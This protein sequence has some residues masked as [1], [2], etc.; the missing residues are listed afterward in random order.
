M[1]LDCGVC[2]EFLS[3]EDTGEG[4]LALRPLI[5]DL[6]K[7]DIQHESNCA[8]LSPRAVMELSDRLKAWACG[9]PL[10]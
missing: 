8:I 1:I 9:G 2:G 10:E 6:D 3:I 7:P 4:M 5:I